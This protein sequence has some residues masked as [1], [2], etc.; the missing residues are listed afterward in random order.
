[1]RGLQRPRGPLSLPMAI[2]GRLATIPDIQHFG[3]CSDISRGRV[4]S[5]FISAMSSAHIIELCTQ[6]VSQHPP[7]SVWTPRLRQWSPSPRCLRED[8]ES[9][10]KECVL[11]KAPGRTS[12]KSLE[13]T[14]SKEC[15]NTW[16]PGSRRNRHPRA[17]FVTKTTWGNLG[18]Q[19][20]KGAHP[21]LSWLRSLPIYRNLCVLHITHNKHVPISS[22]G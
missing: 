8:I 19:S 3:F 13:S 12:R 9:H 15:T 10:A 18:T 1:M 22:R 2:G 16:D 17:D 11:P 21:H 14:G 7:V 5:T 6:R 4:L 20:A